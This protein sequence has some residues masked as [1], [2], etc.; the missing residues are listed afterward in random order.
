MAKDSG[1]RYSPFAVGSYVCVITNQF[2]EKFTEN[3]FVNDMKFWEA[4]MNHYLETGKA[5]PQ[6]DPAH[7]LKYE[8]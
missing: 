1:C 3:N 6:S 8:S 4:T 7:W 2:I 5:L